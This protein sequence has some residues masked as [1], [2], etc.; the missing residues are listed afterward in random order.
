MKIIMIR[1]GFLG[2]QF[3][4]R[5]DYDQMEMNSTITHMNLINIQI[6]NMKSKNN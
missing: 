4:S 3:S 1:K 2:V 5:S 6:T